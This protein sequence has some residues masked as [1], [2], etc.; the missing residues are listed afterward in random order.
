MSYSAYLRDGQFLSL[1][2]EDAG[3]WQPVTESQ[4]HTLLRALEA[5]ADYQCALGQYRRTTVVEVHLDVLPWE[6][7][8]VR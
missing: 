7:A 1:M 6:A 3:I 5:D 2:D 8:P 4:R